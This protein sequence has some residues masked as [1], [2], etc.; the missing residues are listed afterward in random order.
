[1]IQV[2]F[3]R[4]E[5]I[6][7]IA[8]AL[9]L[10]QGAMT[11][12]AKNK[13]AEVV[14]KNGG[15]YA[16]SYAD[17]ADVIEVMRKP[18]SD[19]GLAVVQWPVT[20]I[21]DNGDQTVMLLTLL[22]HSSGQWMEARIDTGRFASDPQ[23]IGAAITYFKRYTLQSLGLIAAEGDT[24]A[25]GLRGGGSGNRDRD[26]DRAPQ[27]PRDE[28][29][30]QAPSPQRSSGRDESYESARPVQEAAPPPT[31]EPA[32]AIPDAP[33][34]LL[35]AEGAPPTKG[36]LLAGWAARHN[37]TERVAAYAFSQY[38]R[39]VDQLTDDQAAAV[40]RFMVAAKPVDPSTLPSRGPGAKN[41]NGNPI[42]FGWPTTGSALFAWSKRLEEAFGVGFVK[43][44]DSEFGADPHNFPRTY[45]D[46]TEAQ[47][48]QAA[49]SVARR[50]KDLPGYDGQFDH[51]IP[52]LKDLKARLLTACRALSAHNGQRDP[53]YAV[54][55]GL[56]QRH[57]FNL[58]AAA[59]GG[60]ILDDIDQCDNIRLVQAVLASIEKDLNEVE[61]VAPL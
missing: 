4:S 28:S 44:I 12:V 23:T 14:M 45:K 11:A 41:E 59:A 40:Y 18:L 20:V 19:N 30:R 21:H 25:R 34:T 6:H 37:H 48:E 60:E 50:V 31:P 33:A 22:T 35:P 38:R 16:Y 7:E 5:A 36:Q 27:R 57:A 8:A 56:C 43:A 42:R 24:D 58:P 10:A 17:I 39:K 47:V 13:T 32:A 51:R 15:K 49:V 29:R 61:N 53:S 2:A 26:R 3:T 9:A 54:V 46:W 52:D 55:N 1:M